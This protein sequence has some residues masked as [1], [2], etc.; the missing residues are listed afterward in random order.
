MEEIFEKN[1]ELFGLKKARNFLTSCDGLEITLTVLYKPSKQQFSS[2][3]KGKTQR[4]PIT[5][6]GEVMTLNI[7]LVKAVWNFF[8]ILRNIGRYGFPERTSSRPKYP[9]EPFTQ[10]KPLFICK[11]IKKSLMPKNYNLK[12]FPPW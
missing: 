11:P 1:L 8:R 5:M 10:E 6:L 3:K 7:R 4:K 9:L 12:T 2:T